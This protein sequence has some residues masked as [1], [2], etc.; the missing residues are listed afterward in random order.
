[1]DFALASLLLTRS[2]TLFAAIFNTKN[3]LGVSSP[4]LSG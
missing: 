4:L 3:G 1:M 2:R